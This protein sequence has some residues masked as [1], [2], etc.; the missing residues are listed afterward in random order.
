MYLDTTVKLKLSHLRD[1]KKLHGVAQELTWPRDC[2][3][4]F[5]TC[6]REMRKL[7]RDRI[8]PA[9]GKVVVAAADWDQYH[10]HVG[11]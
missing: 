10:I 1:N 9:T 6:V 3:D 4:R 11:C 7:A 2:G 8:D 5:K